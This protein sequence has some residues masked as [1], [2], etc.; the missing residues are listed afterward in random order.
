MAVQQ[1]GAIVKENGW[2]R[3]FWWSLKVQLL[4]FLQ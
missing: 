4:F 1:I 2:R 3:Y